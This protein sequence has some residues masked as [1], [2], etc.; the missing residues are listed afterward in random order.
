[1]NDEKELQ[2]LFDRTAAEPSAVQWASIARKAAMIP[3]PRR[4]VALG[5]LAGVT[6]SLVGAMAFLFL[7]PHAVDRTVETA[8]TWTA[9]ETTAEEMDDDATTGVDALEID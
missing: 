7:R 4:T 1:V 6:L 5:F 9:E 3:T 2:E 8:P